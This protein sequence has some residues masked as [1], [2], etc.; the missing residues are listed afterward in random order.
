MNWLKQHE[1]GIV[2]LAI[3]AL[4]GFLDVQHVLPSEFAAIILAVV[5]ALNVWLHGHSKGAEVIPLTNYQELAGQ[6]VSIVQQAIQPATPSAPAQA[7][8]TQVKPATP[9]QQEVKPVAQTTFGG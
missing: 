7:E 5:T 4:T 1:A 2:S 6:L 3:L 8:V 9:V